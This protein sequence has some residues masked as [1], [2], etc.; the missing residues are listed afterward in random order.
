MTCKDR[1]GIHTTAAADEISG[2]TQRSVLGPVLFLM[3]INDLPPS[4][5]NSCYLFAD[6]VKVAG[7]DLDEDI[8]AML[9]WSQKWSLP[10]VNG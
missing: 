5:R 1:V 6:D 3:F 10:N 8:E 7:A 2:A 4:L 9:P